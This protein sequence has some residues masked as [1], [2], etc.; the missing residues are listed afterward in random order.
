MTT[1]QSPLRWAALVGLGSAAYCCFAFVWFVFPAFLNPISA[2][3]GLTSTEAG[4]VNGTIPLTYIP[5]AL[6]S[7]L[8]IDRIGPGRAIGI[9]LVVMGAAQAVRATV[10]GF[11]GLVLLTAAIGLGGTGITFGL[12]K[13]VSVVVPAERSGTATSVYIVG[14]SAGTAA[15]FSLGRPVL[16]PMLG[17]WRP[18]F[19]WSG[20][21][22]VG[23][24]IVWAVAVWWL[25]ED[26]ED[27][28]EDD[29]PPASNVRDDLR[30]VFSNHGLRLLVVVGTMMLFV[31]HGTQAWLTA[32]FE[33]RGFAAGLA[34]LLTTG[35]V[36]A[37]TVGVLVIPPIS[38]AIGVRRAVLIA[39]GAL[40]TLGG[41]LLVASG[42]SLALSVA[43]VGLVGFGIGGLSPLVRTV[44]IELDGI[45]PRL[46]ATATGLIFAVGEA[47]GFL[48]PVL[49]G[50]IFDVTGAYEPAI[51]MVALAG[52]VV[53]AAAWAM[54][55][56]GDR[57]S[58]GA[59][60]EVD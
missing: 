24:A 18:V 16:G 3:L 1:E 33:E 39:S 2:E 52:T 58:T 46:T 5:I 36:A 37:R 10:A 35:L 9:G 40:V 38:D 20:V 42:G 13:L 48:G 21:A 32:I 54:P 31:M 28:P 57:A 55:E 45:G 44:P 47:G 23:F 26:A 8:V 49:V 4:L 53:I 27:D 15:A 11:P 41:G 51:A 14:A 34:A 17:G 22:V 25:V 6:A 19:R 56:T 29:A 59:A 12:P 7:G 43:A 30:A 50:W 60:A